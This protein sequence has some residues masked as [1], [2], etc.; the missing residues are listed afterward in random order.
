[1]NSRLL[2]RGPVR[3]AKAM[4]MRFA[5]KPACDCPAHRRASTTPEATSKLGRWSLLLPLLA[6]AICPACL[7]TYAKLLSL[8][9]VGVGMTESQ[10]LLVLGAAVLVSVIVSG[11]RSWRSKRWWP[12]SL[13][14][15]GATLIG[16][17]H[18][19]EALH[20]LEW[21]GVLVL[22]IGGLSEHLRLRAHTRPEAVAS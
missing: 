15:L 16:V 6:C 13:A 9:G 20:A 12:I 7:A 21:A 5:Q 10:H 2:A 11:L 8:L 1:L 14:L 3:A 17:G 22:L 19:V 18:S 4:P